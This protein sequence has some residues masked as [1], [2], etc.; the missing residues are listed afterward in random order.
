MKRKARRLAKRAASGARRVGRYVGG[1]KGTLLEGGGGV[2][3]YYAMRFL[4]SNFEQ[5]N[6]HWYLPPVV[7]AVGAHILKKRVPRYAQAA[8]AAIGAAGAIG[9]MAYEANK[10]AEK[11][12]GV[13]TEGFDT[14][15]LMM[16]S[17]PTLQSNFAL[18]QFNVP[19]MTPPVTAPEPE[20]VASVNE[21][22]ALGL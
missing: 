20:P 19:S 9:A 1:S 13:S 10:E 4:T 7:M 12:G 16:G 2:A 11:Q 14:G 15:V 17:G 21:A 8:S 18:D 3:A 22:A 5:V 6:K